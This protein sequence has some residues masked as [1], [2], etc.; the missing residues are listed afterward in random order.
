VTLEDPAA[1]LPE[2]APLVAVRRGALVESFHRG[3]LAVCDPDG[4]VVEV[5]GDPEGYVYARSSAK[6]FQALPLVLSGAADA[7]GLTDE[8]L[9]VACASHNAE[10][11]HLRSVRSILDKAGLSEDDLQNGAHPPLYA[12]AAMELACSGEEPGAIHGNCSG[13]HAGMLAVCVH[14]GWATGGYRN[15]DHP[16]QLWI[17]EITG[18]VCGVQTDEILLAGDG[19]GVPTFGMPLRNLATGF[20]RLANGSSLPD[21]LAAAVERV[22]RAMRK[23]S[24][25][26]AGTDRFDTAVM[27]GTDLVCKSGA[28]IVFGAGSA[29]GWGL[30]LKISD[31]GARALRPAALAAFSRRGVEVPVEPESSPV[32]DLHGEVVG[33]RAPLL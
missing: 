3:R 32:H 25:L 21:E 1:G 19:C 23:H 17:M 33:E 12:P 11:P 5:V 4:E 10:E 9:A 8:E 15:L 16:L 2:D 20:A 31:G 7:L 27:G 28:E 24:Y 18:R 30:A 13:K 29:E 6:P 26:V 22:R 14:R